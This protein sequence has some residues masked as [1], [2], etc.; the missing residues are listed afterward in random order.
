MEQRKKVA[1]SEY[2]FFV[3]GEVTP[4]CTIGLILQVRTERICFCSHGVRYERIPS[5]VLWSVSPAG[6]ELIWWESGGLHNIRQVVSV[7]WLISVFRAV[8]E[9]LTRSLTQVS[10]L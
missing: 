3:G 7:L 10:M 2:V 9:L 1:W 8:V 6:S 4:G 5:K